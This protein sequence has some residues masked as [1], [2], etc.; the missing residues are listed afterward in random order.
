MDMRFHE[1]FRRN[2][3]SDVNVDINHFSLKLI[4]FWE[5]FSILSCNMSKPPAAGIEKS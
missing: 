2:L 4:V 1:T 5:L 3:M